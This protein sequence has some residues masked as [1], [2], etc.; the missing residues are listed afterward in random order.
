M[1]RPTRVIA[2]HGAITLTRQ[3]LARSADSSAST[4]VLTR[5]SLGPSDTVTLVSDETIR[6][7]DRPWPRNRSK[8]PA[9]QP[10][11]CHMPT[12]SIDYLTLPLRRLTDLNPALFSPLPT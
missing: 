1:P 8:I 11:C 3:T 4:S 6:A 10:T 5:F 2:A 7:T 9:R 12:H